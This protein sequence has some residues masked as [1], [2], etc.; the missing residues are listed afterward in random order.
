MP[1]QDVYALSPDQ[2]AA[3]RKSAEPVV[4]N[5]EAAVRKA[6]QDPRAIFED[7]RKTLADYKSGY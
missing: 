4:A 7:L 2:L 5:W 1:G 6:G 3:W